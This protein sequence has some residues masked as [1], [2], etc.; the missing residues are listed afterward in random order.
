MAYEQNDPEK[1]TEFLTVGGL[2]IGTPTASQKWVDEFLASRRQGL[3]IRTFEYY[4]DTLYRLIGTD[5]TPEGIND[6]LHS[7]NLGNATYNHYQS[8]KIF[9]NWLYKTKKIKQNPMELVGKP[10]RSIRIE[11]SITIDQLVTLITYVDNPRDE[12]LLRFLFDNGCRLS[13]VVGIKDT[14]FDWNK[15]TV[16]VIGKGDVQRN[17][18][19]TETTE[20]HLKKWFSEH[21]TFELNKSGVQSMLKRLEKKTGVDCNPHAFRHGFVDNQLRKKTPIVDIMHLG[22]WHDIKTVMKY[23]EQYNQKEALKHYDR[24]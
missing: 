15:G 23:A 16:T 17:A 10:K 24:G 19:F 5:L 20:K 6:W 8:T 13:E 3:S 18:P 12:C 7:L 11:P 14:D 4:R 9:C 2:Q 1:I 22:G 21:K